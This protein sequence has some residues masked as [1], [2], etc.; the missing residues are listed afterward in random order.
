M[1]KDYKKRV[2]YR[3]QGSWIWSIIVTIPMA[4][5]LVVM[6]TGGSHASFTPDRQFAF[7]V[8]WFLDV[9]LFFRM[10]YTGKTDSYRAVLFILFALALSFTFIVHMFEA[11][12]NMTFDQ[13]DSLQCKIPF[14]HIVTTMILIPAALSKSIIFPGSIDSGFASIA[15]MLVIVMG[16]LL[17]LGRGFCSWGCFY[18]GWDDGFSRLRKKAVWK[19]PPNYLRWGGFAVLI[20]VALTSAA[21]LV[22]TYCDWV[23]PFKM[24]TEF[25]AITG[26]ESAIKTVVFA[27]LFF[28]L[29]VVLPIT[30]RKRTQCAWFCPMGAL[31]SL[32]NP[33]NV[34]EVRIDRERCIQCGKCVQVCPV[35]ALDAAALEAGK[36]HINCVKCGKC[37]DVCKQ[38]SI[39]YR[40]KF[41]KLIKHPTTARILYL[42][43]AFGFLAVF[44]GGTLQQAVLMI[45]NL[46][47]TGRVT[48]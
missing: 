19:N 12:G 31:C 16:A 45:L 2:I 33:L 8:I 48:L 13:A 9:V 20:L 7:A 21:A 27:G 3:T 26:V 43:A 10:L 34:Y 40:L 17:I 37:A 25:E 14:C 46:V 32:T 41:T 11:R 35:Q 44:S 38:N 36:P 29:V 6:L 15:S 23:C 1:K 24:V 47:T 18:G 22:P 4:L 30:T 28:G 42:Y 5:I 39:G